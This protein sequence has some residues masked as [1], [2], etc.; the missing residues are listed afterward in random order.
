[1]T[2]EELYQ[3]REKLFEEYQEKT[4]KLCREFANQHNDIKVGDIIQTVGGEPIKVESIDLA[5]NSFYD[6]ATV[7]MFNYSGHACNKDGVVPKNAPYKYGIAQ[8]WVVR[9]N[10]K[11]YDYNIY[12]VK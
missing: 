9:V 11:Q 12:K 1:M 3:E 4:E 2:R 8:C 7:P 6:K 5:I 10:E